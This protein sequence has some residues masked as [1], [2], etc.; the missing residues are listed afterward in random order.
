MIYSVLFGTSEVVTQ[1]ENQTLNLVKEEADIPETMNSSNKKLK[2]DH[3]SKRSRIRNFSAGRQASGIRLL[4]LAVFTELFYSVYP[5]I[6]HSKLPRNSENNKQSRTYVLE[7]C[8]L[9]V[10]SALF[11]L[12]T[13]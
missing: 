1:T 7:C 4:H 2:Q 5:E 11:T 8:T 3:K 6:K 9:L 10:R 13:L 12:I